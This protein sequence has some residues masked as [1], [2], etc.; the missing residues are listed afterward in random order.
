MDKFIHRENL[1]HFK[2]LIAE[3][4]DDIRREMLMKLLAEEEAKDEGLGVDAVRYSFIVMD[5]HH[6]LLAGLPAHSG[7]PL[8]TDIVRV[9]RHVSKVPKL[10]RRLQ[11]AG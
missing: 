5:L 9:G 2:K 8:D 10:F 4:K 6:L 11:A 3:A 1:A 7:L